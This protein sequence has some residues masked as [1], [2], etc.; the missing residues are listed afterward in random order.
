MEVNVN[1]PRSRAFTIFLRFLHL[2]LQL[3]IGMEISKIGA[4]LCTNTLLTIG[5]P[6]AIILI[7]FNI[8]AIAVL[9]CR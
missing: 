3:I 6:V 2:G 4:N 7:L 9:R 8:I 5:E 1:E